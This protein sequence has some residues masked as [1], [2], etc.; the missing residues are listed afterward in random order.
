MRKMSKAEF[1]AAL[2]EALAGLPQE[3]IEKSLDFY[4]EMIDDRVEDGFSE[5][6]AVA[7][8]GSVDEIARQVLSETPLG[9]I[10]RESVRP[11]RRLCGWE[12]ALLIVGAPLWLP[13]AL[14][15]AVV[16]LALYLVMWAAIV[17][18][19]AADLAVA[20]CAAAGVAG[21]IIYGLAS[22]AAAA[23]FS[24]GLALACAGAAILLF[25]GFG[26][27][28]GAVLRLGKS[29]LDSLKRLFIRRKNQ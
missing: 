26:Y 11:A 21:I 23:V 28:S 24:F 17:S 27:V 19:Y 1:L 2:R 9:R 18:L 6:D 5:Q 25:F 4:G 14:A 10:V 15:A 7:A 16:V 20:L 13:L 12:T 8:V 22:R 29:C 3:D